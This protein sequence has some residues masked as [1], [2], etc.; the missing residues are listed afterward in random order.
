MNLFVATSSSFVHFHLFVRVTLST[1]LPSK[2]ISK[3]TSLP[4]I[5]ETLD[6]IVT[7]MAS[8]TPGPGCLVYLT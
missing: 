8:C 2:K 7:A 1:T 4:Q 3:N 5:I 6:T